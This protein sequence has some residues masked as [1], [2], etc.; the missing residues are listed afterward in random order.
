MKTLTGKNRLRTVALATASTFALGLV[1]AGCASGSGG[2]AA[3]GASPE[4]LEAALEAGGEITY[5]SWT[6]SAEAQ[7]A[8]FEKAYPKVDVKLV[9]AGTNTDEYTKLQNAITAGSGA[10]DVAQVEYYAIP[11]F[12]LSDSLVDL[13]PYG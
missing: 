1:L 5:W 3:A 13:A 9:N 7:V 4:A 8:A 10:P 6:P 11:Q 2:D 12:S